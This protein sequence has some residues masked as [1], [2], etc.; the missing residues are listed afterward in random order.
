MELSVVVDILL[1]LCVI[2]SATGVAVFN[3]ACRLIHAGC[4]VDG[5]DKIFYLLTVTINIW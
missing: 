5:D 2:N 3:A 4:T 1:T